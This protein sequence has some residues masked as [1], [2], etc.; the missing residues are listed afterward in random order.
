MVFRLK[1]GTDPEEFWKHWCEEHGPLYANRCGKYLRKYVVNRVIEVVKGEPVVWGVVETWWK[2]KEEYAKAEETPAAKA[3][4]ATP[5]SRY[6]GEH[7]EGGFN[8]WIEE[9]QIK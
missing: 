3:A 1:P 4:K 7:I 5:G 2:N 6:F 8:A 9:K